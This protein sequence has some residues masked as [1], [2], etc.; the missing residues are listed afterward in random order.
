[1]LDL[2][3]FFFESLNLDLIGALIGPLLSP[4]RSILLF[5][6]PLVVGLAGLPLAWR[7][8]RRS[9]LAGLVMGLLLFLGQGLFYRENWAGVYGW[10]LRYTLPLLPVLIPLLVAPVI[11]VLLAKG[12]SGRA[13]LWAILWA[14]VSVQLAGVLPG[15][16]R[17]Y[18]QWT[19]SGLDPYTPAAAWDADLN[20]IAAGWKLLL[21]PESWNTAWVRMLRANQ[22][23]SWLSP[24]ALAIAAALVFVVWYKNRSTVKQRLA[25]SLL[26]GLLPIVFI[27]TLYRADPAWGG[28]QPELLASIE[29]VNQHALPSEPVVIDA[30]ATPLWMAAMN[31]WRSGARWYS[32]PY[33]IPQGSA[34]PS[35]QLSPVSRRL[36]EGLLSESGGLWYVI[37]PD[38]P[39]YAYHQE[40]QW[41]MD[42]V[43]LVEEHQF[44]SGGGLKIY[45]FGN[46]E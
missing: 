16:Q 45:R 41:L 29:Y 36:L 26:V 37:S 38:A 32:L 28:D 43:E 19:A 34:P 20:A 2:A 9:L 4:S 40:A 7:K 10:G 44:G 6:P 25:V 17:I 5:S 27:P 8:H 13:A 22:T 46:T 3:H 35:E 23:L 18:A 39:D 24:L 21:Q 30:Y 42:Q 1:M 11:D 12:R 14:G 33:E 31:I 15:W